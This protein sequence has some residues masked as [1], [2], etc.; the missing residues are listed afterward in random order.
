MRV[1]I[2]IY[3]IGMRR[4]VL[5]RVLSRHRFVES[6]RSPSS[7][8]LLI[9]LTG[10]PGCSSLGALLTE[11]GPFRVNPDGATLSI[12]PYAW[13]REAN[14]LAIESPAGV[15]FSYSSNNDVSNNDNRVRSLNG[16]I[17]IVRIFR[18]QMRTIMH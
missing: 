18:Q 9:W 5:D 2:D 8:P 12:N 13:N 16:Y 10:G 14:V 3:T 11:W 7:D 6:Q 4:A 1:V 15:G 17:Y